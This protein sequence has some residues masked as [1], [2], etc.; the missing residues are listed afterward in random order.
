LAVFGGW[1]DLIYILYVFGLYIKYVQNKN[2]FNNLF[3]NVSD[4]VI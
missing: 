3:V 4:I 2:Y 1:Q